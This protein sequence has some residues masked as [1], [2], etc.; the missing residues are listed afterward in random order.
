MLMTAV[1][2][3]TDFRKSLPFV[4][5]FQVRP[6]RFDEVPP[7]A[8]F[9]NQFRRSLNG[10]EAGCASRGARAPLNL[11]A[12]VSRRLRFV[13]FGLYAARP[14]FPFTSF[15]GWACWSLISFELRSTECVPIF[16]SVPVVTHTE[17]EMDRILARAALK[18]RR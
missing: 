8:Q 6:H 7:L 4:G 10:G 9:G 16:C 2:A 11:C 3:L 17:Y 1:I 14:A 5:L 12:R 15:R 18:W 13:P